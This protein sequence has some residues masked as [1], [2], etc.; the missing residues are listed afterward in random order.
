[1]QIE[2]T[3]FP[4]SPDD[5][6]LPINFWDA[7]I[8]HTLCHLSWFWVLSNWFQCI[9]GFESIPFDLMHALRSWERVLDRLLS[10][11]FCHNGW[12]FVNEKNSTVNLINSLL[13]PPS[14]RKVP[15]LKAIQPCFIVLCLDLQRKQTNITR[16][17]YNR[18]R[19][20]AI[21]GPTLKSIILWI[22]RLLRSTT[23]PY[24]L[25]WVTNEM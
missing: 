5:R 21:H 1:M 15:E 4:S 20:M 17:I 3:F 9:Y 7:M 6:T 22:T 11:F 19:T 10:L 24:V 12:E 16:S 18:G 13:S 25:R 8:Y 14:L 2:Q 23:W